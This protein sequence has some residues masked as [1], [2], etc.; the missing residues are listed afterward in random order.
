MA[1]ITQTQIVDRGPISVVDIVFPF[2]EENGRQFSVH[3]TMNTRE[4]VDRIC[5]II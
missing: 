2:Q 4:I 1:Y 3:K 5:L